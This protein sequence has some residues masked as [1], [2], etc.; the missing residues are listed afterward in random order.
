MLEFLPVTPTA[1]FN[2]FFFLYKFDLMDWIFWPHTQKIGT[3]VDHCL[4]IILSN[5][6]LH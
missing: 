4:N 1:V 6:A 5:D 3:A 2:G